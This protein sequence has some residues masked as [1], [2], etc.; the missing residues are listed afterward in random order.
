M[1]SAGQGCVEIGA[2]APITTNTC[3]CD[4]MFA[5]HCSLVVQCGDGNNLVR[6]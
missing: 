4:I 2:D 5:V 6:E 3:S 1:E